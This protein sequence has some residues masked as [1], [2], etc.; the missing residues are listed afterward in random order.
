[1][2]M[3]LDFVTGKMEHRQLNFNEIVS[4]WLSGEDTY[5]TET[6]SGASVTA[7]SALTLTAVYSCVRL[8]SWTLASLPLPVYENMVPRGKRRVPKNPIY[9]LLHDEP[10]PEQTSFQWR[11]LMSVHQNLWGAGIS[12][13]E[14][15]ALGDPIALWPIPPWRVEPI[16]VEETGLFYKVSMSTG[17]AKYLLPSQVVVF[18]ALSTSSYKWMSPI[19]THRETIGSAMA[20]NAFGAKTFGQ[21]TNPAGVITHPDK[22]DETAQTSLRKEMDGYKGLGNS[23]RL[24]LLEDGMKFERVGLPPE[25][26]QYL[27][28]RRFDI[29]EIAR[30]YNVPLYMLNDHEKQ[31]S[32]GTGIE[33]QK[34]GFVT[35][36]MRP[37]FVQWEQEINRRLVIDE[38]LFA[39][40]LIAGLL[41]G[42]LSDRYE[43][44][45][46]GR[47]W[48]WLS[49][50]DVRDLENMNPLPDDIGEVYLT[51][52]NMQSAE[53][54]K[55]K[56]NNNSGNTNQE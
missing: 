39:E 18:P 6:A 16:K 25:D 5:P 30:I 10:N 56:P 43:A 17:P 8:I 53:F 50:N 51:P 54:A 13:I 14:F 22:L 35:F 12:E 4:N 46:K 1:M 32:W 48:G 28:T 52:L 49:A 15:N 11:A 42:K 7:S 55:E 33:E 34:D 24:M 29:S 27:E 19:S 38:N 23:H 31:T 37:Y 3:L 9:K 41:R 40:F 2:G 47:S 21:G 44:Y 36:T 45:T 20:V 26:A